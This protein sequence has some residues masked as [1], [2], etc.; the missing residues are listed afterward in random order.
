MKKLLFLVFLLSLSF[1][2]PS[3]A[4]VNGDNDTI[5]TK[6]INSVDEIKFSPRNDYIL[7]LHRSTSGPAGNR[8]WIFDIKNGDLLKQIDSTYSLLIDSVNNRIFTSCLKKIYAWDIGTYEKYDYFEPAENEIF[9]PRYSPRNNRIA[10][11]VGLPDVVSVKGMIKVW[12]CVS[13]K[14][15]FS[16]IYDKYYNPES[17][18]SYFPSYIDVILNDGLNIM[19]IYVNYIDYHDN[20]PKKKPYITKEIFEVYDATTFE[21]ISDNRYLADHFY[22]SESGKY[23]VEFERQSDGK[24]DMIIFQTSDFN[25]IARI[26][27]QNREY[28][29]SISISKDD[30]YLVYALG[31]IKVFDLINR[32]EIYDYNVGTNRCLDIGDD[33]KYI[34]SSGSML[35]LLKTPWYTSV[36]HENELNAF[37]SFPNPAEK[38]LNVS[39]SLHRPENTI[40]EIID[41]NGKIV[42]VLFNGLLTEGS[43]ELSFNIESISSGTYILRINSGQSSFSQKFI[44]SN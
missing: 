3:F 33:N 17:G 27:V 39:F 2:F 21:Y 43:H 16:K 31:H 1:A 4:Q 26:P 37:I 7:C 5:W 14:V 13:G 9:H 15:I 32:T 34:V 18:R 19:G 41:L 22:M 29:S 44:I 10:A 28:V 6:L 11:F 23:L 42:S 36:Q 12:D 24:D 35:A 25:V 40:I 30:K 8:T 38:V 20:D